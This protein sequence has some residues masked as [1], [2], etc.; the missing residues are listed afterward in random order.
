[1]N[2]KYQYYWIGICFITLILIG[3]FLIFYYFD[4]KEN[5]CEQNPLV[6]GAKKYSKLYNYE[7]QGTGFFKVPKNFKSP[8]FVFNSTDLNIQN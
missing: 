8:V 2:D 4:Y 1:M 5:L 3:V 7:F 6:Y